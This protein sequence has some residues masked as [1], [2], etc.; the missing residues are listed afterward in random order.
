[1]VPLQLLY[2]EG[3]QL[4]KFHG[5]G[6]ELIKVTFIAVALQEYETYYLQHGDDKINN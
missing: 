1:M 2:L 3:H 4:L 6:Q 5:L